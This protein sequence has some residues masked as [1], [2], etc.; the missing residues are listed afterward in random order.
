MDL[1][2]HNVLSAYREQRSWNCAAV[3]PSPSST[4]RSCRSI[5]SCRIRLAILIRESSSSAPSSNVRSTRPGRDEISS[6]LPGQP[7]AGSIRSRRLV[8]IAT[9]SPSHFWIPSRQFRKQSNVSDCCSFPTTLTRPS[10]T[11]SISS[12]TAM[13]GTSDIIFAQ[14]PCNSSLYMLARS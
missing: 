12:I 4:A 9:N 2:G 11:A 5:R 7:S 14:A 13:Q 1:L 3:S 8:V 10:N 6:P